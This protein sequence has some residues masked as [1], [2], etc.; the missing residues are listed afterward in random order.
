MKTICNWLAT[1]LIFLCVA[2]NMS[3]QNCGTNQALEQI[4]KEHPEYLQEREASEKITHD[5]K[6][7]G[8]QEYLPVIT[9][10]VVVHVVWYTGVPAQNISDAQINSQIAVLNADFRKQNLD[11]INVPSYFKPLAADVQLQFCMAQRSPNC[12]PTNGITRTESATV[13]WT[14]NDNVKYSNLGGADAWNRDDY[15]N[16][17]VCDL[18]SPSGYAHYPGM[19]SAE[20]D[21]IVVDYRSFGTMGTAVFPNKGG[22]MATH[23]VGHWLN[24]I[25]IFG[26]DDFNAG[27]CSGS[28]LVADT[29]NQAVY[30]T[31][32]PEGIVISCDNAPNGDMYMNYMDYTDDYC[33][34]M[35][36][37]G[38][39]KR[40]RD[41]FNI[42]RSSL[43]SS[44]GCQPLGP[45]D[46]LPPF[47]VANISGP[48]QFCTAG[49]Q[50]Y[51]Y[52][53]SS[54]DPYFA[55]CMEGTWSV[56]WSGGLQILNQ[57]VVDDGTSSVFLKALSP[58]NYTVTFTVITKSCNPIKV[59][60]SYQVQVCAI[61]TAPISVPPPGLGSICTSDNPECYAFSN[62]CGLSF[63]VSTNDPYLIA[64]VSGATICLSST[65]YKKR[66][67]RLSVTPINGCGQGV[68]ANWNIT[69]D[70]PAECF[71]LAPPDNPDSGNELSG[72]DVEQNGYVV[73]CA[74]NLVRIEDRDTETVQNEKTV[75]LLAIDGRLLID[76]H[77]EDALIQMDLNEEYPSGIYLLRIVK[78]GQVFSK[79]IT[80]QN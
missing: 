34:I 64:T 17:W 51:G 16:I 32:C 56:S 67:S 2:G 72:K 49:S 25:H 28:D 3:S 53:T 18:G 11:A 80:I 26:E 54:I 48:S 63:L 7:A 21:G 78:A 45:C 38:Q 50:A 42:Y 14:N 59:S 13:S 58:G 4:L 41:A 31:G 57:A 5:K 47:T 75:Q 15:L 43:A 55:E 20:T 71:A 23:E 62:N 1:A 10:P 19:G 79:K 65:L 24:L 35:F 73:T 70:N 77:T 27:A 66:I 68:T 30:H 69:I 44:K 74:R 36:T 8:Q 33:R 39:K 6:N 12:Q 60:K 52:L 40:M 29:P 46:N 76:Y 9:I 61:P 22:R 37:E